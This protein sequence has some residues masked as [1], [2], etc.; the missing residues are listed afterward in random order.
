MNIVFSFP[1]AA[2]SEVELLDPVIA[3][4]LTFLGTSTLF[5]I[6]AAPIDFSLLSTPSLVFVLCRPLMVVALHEAVPHGSFDVRFP[7]D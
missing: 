1:L 6:V 2:F 3:L 5:S 4:F 7:D